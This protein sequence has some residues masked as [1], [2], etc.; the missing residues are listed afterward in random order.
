MVGVAAPLDAADREALIIAELVARGFDRRAV[1]LVAAVLP[2][3]ADGVQPGQ[4]NRV[5]LEVVA[6]EEVRVVVAGQRREVGTV[7][8]LE[9]AEQCI[10]V[11]F[12]VGFRGDR[13]RIAGAPVHL[14]DEDN[15]C[16]LYT[17]PSPRDRQKSR[18]PSS[19]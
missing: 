9:L 16:L 12:A 2:V 1:V 18:M 14:R 6:A 5:P 4:S 8:S 7:P 3:A 10:R 19:A 17:S 13:V 15:L 11:A